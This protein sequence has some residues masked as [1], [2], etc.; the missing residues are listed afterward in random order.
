M[1]MTTDD[2][3]KKLE[4]AK[5]ASGQFSWELRQHLVNVLSICTALQS[6]LAAAEK[7]NCGMQDQTEIWL[8]TIEAHCTVLEDNPANCELTQAIRSDVEEIR[9]ALA[10]A[11]VCKPRKER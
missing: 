8:I 4:E 11:P 9:Q 2:V 3:E 6:R 5:K 10:A 7:T 1:G